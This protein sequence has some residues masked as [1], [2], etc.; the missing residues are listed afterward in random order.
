IAVD[1]DRDSEDY[2]DQLQRT[3][4]HRWRTDHPEHQQH[5]DD[6]NVSVHSWSRA[7]TRSWDELDIRGTDEWKWY[8][9]PDCGRH[10]YSHLHYWRSDLHADR[11]LLAECPT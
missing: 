7:D 5:G 6:R 2:R 10:L 1:H 9:A 4:Q 11:P 3:V 8:G